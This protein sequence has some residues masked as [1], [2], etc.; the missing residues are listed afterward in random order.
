MKHDSDDLDSGDETHSG[1][2]TNLS[3]EINLTRRHILAAFGATGIGAVTSGQT[4]SMFSDTE[5]TQSTLVAG[6]FDMKVDW[7]EIYNGEPVDAYPDENDDDE[8]DEIETRDE[9]AR[10][11][12]GVY[13]DALDRDEQADVEASFRGQFADLSKLFDDGGGRPPVLEFDD[14][15]PGD[16]GSVS[17]SLHL[18]DNPG[19]VWLTGEL[20]ENDENGQTE[21]EVAAEGE[22]VTG[23]GE[24]P[25]VISARA[26]YE[27]GEEI[28]SGTLREVLDALDRRVP[29]DG[30]R[31]ATDRHCF[32]NSET[33]HIRF[34]WEVPKTV[35]NRIQ[36][37]SAAFRL[38][39]Y[40]EQ[41]RHNDG[42]P[43][44]RNFTVHAID[45]DIP[46][47]T[48]GLHQPNGAMYVLEENIEAV[49]AA[50]G[51][52][53]EP[54]DVSVIE[55]LV[56]R[57]N[58][59]DILN[60]EFVNDLDRPASIHPTGL[61][62]DLNTSDGMA[63]GR[64]PDT[65][66]PAGGSTSYRIHA[67][68]EG[69]FYFA[70]GTAHAWDSDPQG[71][72]E[73]TNALARGLFGAILVEPRNYTWT[74][75]VT[76]GT[77]R[78]GTKADIHAPDAPDYREFVPI[79]HDPGDVVPERDFPFNEGEVDHVEGVPQT[80]HG[81]NYRAEK[82]SERV[83]LADQPTEAFYSSWVHGDPGFGDNAFPAYK[84][85]PIKFVPIGAN[86]EE[87][88]VHHLHGHRL[89][90]VEGRLDSDT[91]D[92]Q[93]IGP[94]ATYPQYLIAGAGERTTRP[95]MTFEEAF[96]V[97]AGYVHGS[98][99]DYLFHCHLFPHY[100]EGMN[101][102]M[103]VHDKQRPDLQPLPDN[104][105]EIP[106]D[107]DDLGWIEVLDTLVD[108]G[109]LQ[110]NAPSMSPGNP[111]NRAPNE[112]EQEA[113]DALVPGAPYVDPVVDDDAPVREYTIVALP[114][115]VVY[116]DAG[117]HDPRGRVFVLEEDAEAV[118]N[119]DIN[120]E[121]L[122]IRANVGDAVQIT[123][124]N[125]LTED[126]LLPGEPAGE[127]SNHVHFVG[128]DVLGSDS[129][130]VGYNYSQGVDPGE[131]GTYRWYADEEGAVFFHDHMTATGEGMHGTFAS[132][133]VEPEES[134]WLDPHTGDEIRSGTQAMI[135][136]P[137]GED[138]REFTLLYHDFAPLVE[139]GTTD[140]FV[141]PDTQHAL[142]AGTMAINY[143]NAP[144]YHRDD[145]D[146]AYVHSSA[147]H[148]DPSTPVCEMYED[149]PVRIRLVNGNHEEQHNFTTHG[150]LPNPDGFD[151]ADSTSQVIGP[152]EAF[153]FRAREETDFARRDN[154]NGLPVRDYLYGSA[155]MDDL[156]DGMWGLLRSWGG[157]VNHL[158]PLPDRESP[159]PSIGDDDLREM[160]HPAPFDGRWTELGHKAKLRYDDNADRSRPADH[161]ARRNDQIGAAP[162]KAPNPGDPCPD[163]APVRSYDVTAFQNEIEFN[164]YGD[165][166]PHGIV[167]AIDEHVEE[168]RSGDRPAEPLAIH[169]NAG[170]CVEVTLTN[171]LPETPD[172][173]HADPE[174]RTN[175]P[176]ERSN[177]ISLHPQRLTY[178]VNG[179]DG[180]TV[181]FNYD[182]TIAPGESI[183]YRW[184]AERNLEGC[185]LWDMADPR[186]THHHG[187]SGN[188]YIEPEGSTWLD[189]RT[190]E[191]VS[192]GSD[193]MVKDPNGSDYRQFS[194]SIS[195]KRY[196]VNPDGSCVVP[197]NDDD[198][199]QDPNTPC[200]QIGDAEDQ[201]YVGV[202]NRAEPFSRRFDE[203]PAEHLVY[204]SDIHGDPA[205]PVLNAYLDDP[206]QFQVSQA[207]GGPRG[208]S[209]HIAGH[210]WNRFRR[211]PQT[212]RI[213]VENSISPGKM[214]RIEPQGRAGGLRNETGDFIYQGMKMRRRL[215]AGL[216]GLFRVEDRPEDFA[217]PVQPLPDRSA[218]LSID[219][220]PGW[221]VSRNNASSG[222][223]EATSSG[224]DGLLVG[225]PDSD[226]GNTE[227]GAAYLFYG[228]VDEAELTDLAGADAQFLGETM[229]DRAGI[230]VSIGDETSEFGANAIVIE[231][232]D[233]RYIFDGSDRPTG[234]ISLEEA[235]VVEEK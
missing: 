34:E 52:Y 234:T 139:R 221:V 59:G 123:F 189:S 81:I 183:T 127:V 14:V 214:L 115:D 217:E 150:L 132:L 193:V 82:T 56:L 16:S 124:K 210:L 42:E 155:V 55:P 205:T 196:V 83:G 35:G 102:V 41:C 85:D 18:F 37:D 66:V 122:V 21:A 185:V 168:I 116:N 128:Y 30:D 51:S 173:A 40:A 203:N 49:R 186:G 2:N 200:N 94:G 130:A 109:E 50:E 119:G 226:I 6:E 97:G 24:L 10:E 208:V 230:A 86:L 87:N 3:T 167:Y 75:P 134:R 151:P 201:G 36:T 48:F 194:L 228:P 1:T 170:D 92:S 88:H 191:P 169:T 141:N 47:N 96:S 100:T 180:A 216:W 153:T 45:V 69:A 4:W 95:D 39:F 192:V 26:V 222:G 43:Q 38:G 23:V 209:I 138:F 125:E 165:H 179:S 89:K 111:W 233:E 29:L 142:N 146:A 174:M 223:L 60:I 176:W 73:E 101:A 198:P 220:R 20:L 46:Y 172:D 143:R 84:G 204:S 229:G 135:E 212:P 53:E 207:S 61:P 106:T 227:A 231:T 93:T 108:E 118:R 161:D 166:D 149:D 197:R 113:F 98:A 211:V 182:Q 33:Q 79:Y 156:W 31:G 28:I 57:A 202:N 140:E 117:D 164:D 181:G 120:P 133:I 154:P 160:G 7:Q 107:A 32:S 175:K 17:F 13:Y 163:G 177:R 25:E 152:S 78:S 126:A 77:L 206:V 144:Y 137:N 71:N 219:E 112:A 215:E 224:L 190:A 27:D 103:R 121:P 136:D 22:D 225:V 19:F 91:I 58:H 147:V 184:Y 74:D 162:P 235:D 9:I 110:P 178:D 188:L 114:A 68:N 70:D 62:Y 105:P 187:A 131:E 15:K 199:D 129:T 99:G 63:V 213:G 64:N 158:Q 54:A 65:T 145:E 104:P 11:R 171:E 76:G 12:Y 90:E 157:E 67:D 8:Q 148:G 5:T 218:R 44:V 80:T 232:E 159:E 72:P 195:D